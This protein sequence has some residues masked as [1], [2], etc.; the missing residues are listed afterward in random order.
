[1]TRKKRAG[2]SLLSAI[3]AEILVGFAFSAPD[4]KHLFFERAFG[5][6]YLASYLVIPGWLIA[7]PIIVIPNK[8]A[9]RPTWQLGLIGSSI[10]P[11]I[12]FAIGI[13]FA[14]ANHSGINYKREAWYLAGIAALISACTTAIYLT[15][16]K[17]FSHP[18]PTPST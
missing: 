2:L 8:T 17:L 7:L 5:F 11:G 14:I 9:H 15:S 12:M 18:T 10:G 4:G 6:A 16:L 13:Y 1:M 3:V